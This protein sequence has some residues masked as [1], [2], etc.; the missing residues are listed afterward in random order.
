LPLIALDASTQS[1][2]P[3]VATTGTIGASLTKV[4][5]LGAIYAPISMF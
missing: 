2:Q 5:Q 4:D 1:E 3:M